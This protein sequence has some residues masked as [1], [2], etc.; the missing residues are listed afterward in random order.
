M[1]GRAKGV[2]VS[3]ASVVVAPR[4][5]S[6]TAITFAVGEATNASSVIIK[7]QDDATTTNGFPL[8]VVGGPV[9]IVGRLASHRWSAIRLA[10]V[11]CVVGVIEYYPDEDV[12]NKEVTQEASA[13]LEVP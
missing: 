1:S 2:A 4:S 13:E 5:L 7:D 8:S 10:A 3:N 9:T 6:R 11:D 12:G